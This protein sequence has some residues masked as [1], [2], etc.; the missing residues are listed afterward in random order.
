MHQKIIKS[1]DKISPKVAAKML[2]MW[3]RNYKDLVAFREMN[4]QSNPS[5]ASTNKAE[6]RLA[7]WWFIV[8]KKYREKKLVEEWV[9]KV[10][11]V[12]LKVEKV[13]NKKNNEIQQ[14]YKLGSK[15]KKVIR[16]KN[17]VTPKIAEKR[18]LRWNKMYQDLLAFRA[19]NSQKKPSSTSTDKAEKKL[20]NWWYIIKKLYEEKQLYE[21]WVIKTEAFG[22]NAKK[23][24]NKKSS[25]MPVAGK[26]EE[27]Y[28]NLLDFIERTSN[29]NTINSSIE[30]LPDGD[31]GRQMVY[32][33]SLP[34]KLP[35]QYSKDKNERELYFFI[36]KMK[37][38]YTRNRLSNYWVDKLNFIGV[39]L[40]GAN[41]KHS[42]KLLENW[43]QY[44]CELIEFRKQNPTKW[45]NSYRRT[46]TETRLYFW[47]KN[48]KNWERKNKL[49][50][51]WID[52]LQE[53]GYSFV[54]EYRVNAK[55]RWQT[56]I[57]K[58]IDF[59]KQNEGKFPY[60]KSKDES[61]RKL[62][63]WLRNVK[64]NNKI[65]K[66]KIEH[67]QELEYLGFSFEKI[68]TRTPYHLAPGSRR[69]DDEK[70]Y[71]KYNRLIEFLK[72][73][74]NRFPNRRDS[75]PE[76]KKI[77]IW[78]GNLK[79]AYKNNSLPLE[80]KE[81]MEEIDFS[82]A[83][84]E[85]RKTV[86]NLRPYQYRKIGINLE[87]FHK[88]YAEFLEFRKQ[89][90]ERFPS[91][92]KPISEQEVHLANW[93]QWLRSRYKKNELPQD[94]IEKMQV[95]GCRLETGAASQQKIVLAKWEV[96]T[97]ELIAFKITH[98]RWPIRK[99][100]DMV[101]SRLSRWMDHLK[102]NRIKEKIPNE[103]IEQL[104][105]AGFLFIDRNS[106]NA[107]RSKDYH[108]AKYAQLLTFKEQNPDKWPSRV[109]G[110]GIEKALAIW[111]V[112]LKT[113]YKKNKNV[114]QDLFNKIQ[115][116]GYNLTA[117][118]KE[119]ELEMFGRW[120]SRYNQLLEFIE[121]NNKLPRKS[122]NNNL[123][124]TLRSWMERM[125]RFYR[126]NKMPDEWKDKLIK[127][128]VIVLNKT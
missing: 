96:K 117:G 51:E 95:A 43:K 116:I 98:N 6:A 93:I 39:N 25:E 64:H 94:L 85:S 128:G 4:P 70:F 104:K 86:T 18:E 9:V 124:K 1:E 32:K 35:S 99:T 30:T 37:M 63:A 24:N 74:S 12:G 52:K 114:N 46:D 108:D 65:D 61:E 14:A 102:S 84:L 57:Q 44:Y 101:E 34:H 120:N 13:K 45:P 59:R 15:Y 36:Y 11:A 47:L 103:W 123:E 119:L 89:Y 112:N 3:N 77:G 54:T 41:I 72:T 110:S 58:L 122:T 92:Y 83:K 88:T 75:N 62:S 73:S 5:S 16:N 106:S 10:E 125:R 23:V 76:A 121:S 80:W 27:S 69:H 19:A 115:T 111:L 68:S 66:L 33:K 67:K 55:E 17:G 78:L 28:Q 40:E 22:I 100:S 26:F 71:K 21:Q 31:N 127:V 8:K 2:L 53:I 97:K 126:L 48:L 82:V 50:Q 105:E 113:S 90:P 42:V 81:K 29:K 56:N 38:L 109:L 60:S 79:I 118:K 87:L 91:V 49:K 107:G 20:A 7:R